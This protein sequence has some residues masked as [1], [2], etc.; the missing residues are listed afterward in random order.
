MER[1]QTAGKIRVLVQD[2]SVIH[3]QLLA[4]ALRRHHGL[5]VLSSES[6][7]TVIMTAVERMIDVL[8]MNANLDEQPHR[9]FDALRELRALRPEIRAVLLLDSS[10]P[11]VVLDAFRA[12]ARGVFCRF[13]SIEKLCKCIRCVH[14]G[15]VWA[16]SGEMLEVLEA[17][18]SAPNVRAVNAEGFRSLT[19]REK[20]IIQSLAEGLTNREIAE[21]LRLSQHTV[22]NY[23]FQIFDK[24]GV[25]SRV[26]L[27]FMTL[28]Q[29]S[30]SQSA[31]N[32]SLKN[33]ADGNFQDDST[34]A[35]CQQAAEHGVPIAQIALAEFCRT[36]RGN[37]QKIVEA[38]KWY[39]LASKQILLASTSL[40]KK[41]TPEQLLQAEQMAVEW[42]RRTQKIPPVSSGDVPGRPLAASE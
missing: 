23:L 32:H 37:P 19:T 42:L 39:L 35:E 26:E 3:T 16:N 12:G 8:V 41:M 20:E 7:K 13:E 9:G 11:K 25:S 4:D 27:L 36:R 18:A 38:Y 33:L 31:C 40:S 17:L 24:V 14:D 34:L 5:E 10:K 29:Q 28:S 1:E 22:K 21:R 2:S 15:Q 30:N 6:P